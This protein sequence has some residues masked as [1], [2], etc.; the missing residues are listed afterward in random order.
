[1]AVYRENLFQS[2]LYGVSVHLLL[3]PAEMKEIAEIMMS[4]V[5][6]LKAEG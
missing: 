2:G 6:W 3:C 1:M 4:D 5:R